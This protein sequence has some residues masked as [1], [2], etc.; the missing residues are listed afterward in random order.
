MES[1]LVLTHAD[2]TGS[3][4][5][6]PSLEA[7]AAGLA[8]AAQLKASLT[9]GII[10][11][12]PVLAANSLASSGARLL[13]VSGAAFAQTRYTTDALACEALCRAANATIVLAPGGRVT[14]TNNGFAPL[15]RLARQVQQAVS[16]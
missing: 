7:V 15:D 9:V 5:S 6:K 4:L 3:A 1:I 8:L 10:A 12:D 11:A 16:A 13:V 14:T 2:E